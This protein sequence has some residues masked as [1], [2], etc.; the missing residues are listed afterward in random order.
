M[1]CLLGWTSFWQ[2][3]PPPP[4]PSPP[5]SPQLVVVLLLVIATLV[6][7]YHHCGGGGG[8]LREKMKCQSWLFVY[9]P[10]LAN[11]PS[12]DLMRKHII[13]F[14][15]SSWKMQPKKKKKKKKKKKANH[16]EFPRLLPQIEWR[17]V[18]IRPGVGLVLH[19]WRSHH[20]KGIVHHGYTMHPYFVK[21]SRKMYRNRPVTNFTAFYCV[22]FIKKI[23][24]MHADCSAFILMRNITGGMIRS[25][26]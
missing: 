12:S 9:W 20:D 15:R 7:H 24:Q 11:P 13:I 14:L 19:C 1:W 6:L 16:D 17:A 10:P 2:C 25:N 22:I 21:K 4:P 8:E 26:L 18:R 23:V 3:P 5:P